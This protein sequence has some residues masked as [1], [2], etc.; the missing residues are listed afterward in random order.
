MI[1]YQLRNL[2]SGLYYK[3]GVIGGEWVACDEAAIW[4]TMEE[5]TGMAEVSGYYLATKD[6]PSDAEV[7]V[8]T[9]DT[10]VGV[11][12]LRDLMD[13]QD[14]GDF[15]YNIREQEGKG[16]EGPLVC[17]WGDTCEHAKKLVGSLPPTP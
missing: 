6:C 13:I 15:I 3:R 9:I 2:K 16:W 12:V 7:E 1:L 4:T 11:K 5:A 8:V 17:K 10:E 14:L